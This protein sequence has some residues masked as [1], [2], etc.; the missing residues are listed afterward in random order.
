MRFASSAAAAKATAWSSRPAARAILIDCGFGVRDTAARLA[1]LGSRRRPHRDPRHPRARRSRRRRARVR[2]ALRDSR[3]AHVR[4]AAE[5]SASASRAWTRVYGFDS[6]D[7]FAVGDLEVLP[8]P[9]PHDAREPVQF[10]IADGAHRLGVLT[11]IGMSTPLRRGEPVGLRRAGARVQ[12]RPRHARR[13]ATIRGRSSSG[14]PGA[15][16][17]CTTRLRRRCSRARQRAPAR[18]SSPRTCRGR[19]T[20]PSSRARRS[21]AR[22]AARPTGSASPTRPTDSTGECW[23]LTGQRPTGERLPMEKRRNCTRARPRPCTR[24]TIRT[25]SSC[26]IATTCRR[27]T[28]PS[29]P[30]ST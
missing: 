10:V 16:G 5:V 11:D 21:P 14:S 18:T 6:H 26:T 1:R 3:L 28:A 19:T 4:H 9:V 15:W 13:A 23:A 30:S 24:R 29:S 20:R 25:C 12:P 22:S 27:S 2:R 8:F 17:I 7:R